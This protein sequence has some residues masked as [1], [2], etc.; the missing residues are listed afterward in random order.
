MIPKERKEEELGILGRTSLTRSL[1]PAQ[2]RSYWG[3]QTRSPVMDNAT[4]RLNRPTIIQLGS[5]IEIL[6]YG[7]LLYSFI[8]RLS[9]RKQ[10]VSVKCLAFLILCF[11]GYVV[12]WISH[13]IESRHYIWKFPLKNSSHIFSRKFLVPI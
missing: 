1:H 2:L 3:E 6:M 7:C 12:N 5:H 8:E 11:F 10:Q 4:Y 13:E 9:R